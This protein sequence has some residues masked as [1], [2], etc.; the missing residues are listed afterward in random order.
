[1]MGLFANHSAAL[2]TI[3]GMVPLSPSFL[4]L[5][6]PQLSFFFGFRFPEQ[7]HTS[8]HLVGEIEG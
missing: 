6:L 8:Q 5:P 3:R 1:M 7:T 4:S 2:H